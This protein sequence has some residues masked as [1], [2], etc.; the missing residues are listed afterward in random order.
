[1]VFRI[2]HE[3]WLVRKRAYENIL[4]CVSKVK[5]LGQEFL[6]GEEY[7]TVSKIA[8]LLNNLVE[9]KHPNVLLKG[10][11][12]VEKILKLD[13]GTHKMFNKLVCEGLEKFPL[14]TQQRKL[15][16]EKFLDIL[17]LCRVD[18]NTLLNR[19]SLPQEKSVMF[20]IEVIGA[21]GMHSLKKKLQ[22]ISKKNAKICVKELAAEIAE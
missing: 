9:E 22:E 1:M 20:V 4:A 12:S 21:L 19:L 6:I 17:E 2:R 13:A 3:K 18:A 16:L 7:F 11:E 15:I 10:L 8:A 14:V 5:S